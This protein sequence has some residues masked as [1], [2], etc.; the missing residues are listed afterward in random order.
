ME[1]ALPH[2][3]GF[4]LNKCPPICT[5]DENGVRGLEWSPT[6][7]LFYAG[8]GTGAG[9]KALSCTGT[10]AGSVVNAADEATHTIY[11]VTAVAIT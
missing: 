10:G 6:D 1:N 11:K 2:I 7:F 9:I 3:W 8:A 5:R 4:D